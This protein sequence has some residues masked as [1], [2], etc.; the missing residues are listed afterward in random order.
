MSKIIRLR[1]LCLFL[2]FFVTTCTFANEDLSLWEKRLPI[3]FSGYTKNET[4]IDFPA[5]IVL[6]ET[7]AGAGFKYSDFLSPPDGDLR[8]VADDSETQLEFEVETWDTSGKSYVWVKVPEL[9]K[10]TKIY[11]LWGKAGVVL[12]S[13]TTDG[14]VWDENY[15][16]VWHMNN[17]TDT[18]V[19]DSTAN[20]FHGTKKAV[21][22]PKEVEGVIGK[23]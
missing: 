1:T 20:L 5:L 16:G 18:K 21:D 17:A 6:E 11:A 13:F 19:A 9:T 8:F 4:L 2:V 22:S 23:G 3:T 12:P 7:D 10:D 14:S 15:L